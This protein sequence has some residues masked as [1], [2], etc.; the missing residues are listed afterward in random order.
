M[1][2][3]FPSYVL[4][5]HSFSL[6]YLVMIPD[7]GC[8]STGPPIRDVLIHSWQRKTALLRHTARSLFQ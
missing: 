2:C 3:H 7:G 5:S 1:G 6:R 4:L 8:V